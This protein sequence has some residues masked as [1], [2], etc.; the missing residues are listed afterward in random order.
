[1]YAC[2]EPLDLRDVKGAYKG[3]TG[4]VVVQAFGCWEIILYNTMGLI[5]FFSPYN[6]IAAIGG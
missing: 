2:E 6:M 4:V 3:L 1:M 5:T